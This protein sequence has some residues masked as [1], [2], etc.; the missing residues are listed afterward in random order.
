MLAPPSGNDRWYRLHAI[1]HPASFQEHGNNLNM[2][3]GC[4]SSQRGLSQDI[5]MVEILAL[6]NQ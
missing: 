3:T 2:T 6:I 5:F 1:D 4:R